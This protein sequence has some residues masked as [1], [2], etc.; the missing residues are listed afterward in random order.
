M[1]AI[2]AL[3]IANELF[4]N[5]KLLDEINPGFKF[6]TFVDP[7]I[8]SV[9]SNIQLLKIA[10]PPKSFVVLAVFKLLLYKIEL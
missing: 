4:D 2:E 1:L 8:L 10:F 7:C 6:H 3:P 5:L 9:P